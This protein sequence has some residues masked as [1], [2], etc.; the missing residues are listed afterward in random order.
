MTVDGGYATFPDTRRESP[1]V[2]AWALNDVVRETGCSYSL[3]TPYRPWDSEVEKRAAMFE[4][5]RVAGA[6]PDDWFLIIDADMA[7]GEVSTDALAMIA[8]TGCDVAEVR[9]HDIQV[10][11]RVAG[12]HRFRCLYRALPGLTVE[13][14]HYLYLTRDVC[15]M[16]CRPD[17]LRFLWHL[18]DGHLAPE[19]I[20]DLSHG[21]VTM[22]HFS[23]QRD[24]PRRRQALDY[25]KD[26]DARGLET[27]GDWR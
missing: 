19:P 15:D 23:S 2:Q 6:T 4:C 20:L 25:Y 9:L 18:P 12:E 10:D 24:P 5:G 14:A 11:G 7:L 21:D 8:E 13:R 17:L 22:Q 26:R 1:A 3:R 27:V 16:G